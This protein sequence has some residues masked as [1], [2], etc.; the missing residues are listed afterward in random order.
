[1]D[2]D[3]AIVGCGPAGMSAAIYAGRSGLKTAVFE[4]KIPGGYMNVA[5]LI[6]NYPGFERISGVELAEKMLVQ[7]KKVG[8]EIIGEGIIDIKSMDDEFDITTDRRTTHHAKAIILATGGEYKKMGIEGEEKFLGK[9]VSYCAS[10]DGPLFKGKNVAIIGSGDHA[11]SEA[12]YLAGM[13]KNVYLVS[14]E[15]NLKAEHIRVHQLEETRNVQI[16]AGY[17]AIEVV[18]TDLVEKLKIQEIENSGAKELVVDGI[19]VSIGEIP[20]VTLAKSIGVKLDSRGC[21]EIDKDKATNVPG[22]FAAGDVTGGIRQIVTAVGDGAVAAV[23]S[24][25]HVRNLKYKKE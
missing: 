8:V 19:F 10:C 25:R 12:M 13:A 7:V 17:A 18:G 21:I 20:L 6:E 23:N 2:Y 9:G 11:V 1:M 22:V 4:S 3:L 14:S 5:H 24:I 15:K 16:F